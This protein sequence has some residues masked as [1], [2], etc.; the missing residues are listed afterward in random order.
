MF[1]KRMPLLAAALLLSCVAGSN[2]ADAGVT[3]GQ[4]AGAWTAV[5]SGN[6]GCGATSMYVTFSL[7][8]LGNG[9]ASIQQH[10]T[11]CADSTTIGNAISIN[12]LNARGRG[13]ASLSCGTGCGW[14]FK[15][16]VA[17]GAK[18]FILT[19]VEPTN[20]ANTPTGMAIHVAP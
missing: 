12:T 11:G 10:S 18:S 9:T 13:T 7:N 4:M 17:D 16:Q 3:K 8:L 6:T 20:P 1:T 15:I 5:L 19:D 14:L 2:V